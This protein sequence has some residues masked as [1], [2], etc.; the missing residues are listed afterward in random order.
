M[1]ILLF[2]N[3]A[4]IQKEKD[5]CIEGSTRKF[6][7]EL[8]TFGHDITFYGQY[9]EGVENTTDVFP[10]LE[11]GMSVK[12]IK[13]KKNKILSYLVLYLK[14]IPEIYKADF[15]YFFYPTALRYL[16]FFPILFKRKFGLY[17]RGIDDLKKGESKFFYKKAYK[18]FTVADF[19]TQYVNQVNRKSV[20][21][22]IRPMIIFNESNIENNRLYNHDLKRLKILYLGRMTNDKG[23]IEL[24]HAV[25]VLVNQHYNPQLILVGTGEYIEELKCLAKDLDIL[26][27]TTFQGPVFEKEKLKNYYLASDLYVL[28]TYHEGFP[29]TLYEAM[30]FGTPIVTTFVGG[31]SGVMI[32]RKNCLEIQPKS[33][34][35]LVENLIFAQKNYP[36]MIEMAYQAQSDIRKILETRKESHAQSLHNKLQKL[37]V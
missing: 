20:A 22:T 5:F 18:V 37:Q 35:S 30:I 17:I 19:F 28:P 7:E 23:I 12:G 15:V 24:L 14:A 27:Y 32:N 4:L 34:E 25:K 11:W 26:Q 29:R 21:S 9:L 8:Q 6:A 1:K 16:I 3:S 36:K 2:L 33:V 10:V 31:I 13:R